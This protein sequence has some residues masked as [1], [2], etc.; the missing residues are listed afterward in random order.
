VTPAV[1][2]V[3]PTFDRGSVLALTLPGLAQQALSRGQFEILLIDDGSTDDTRAVAERLGGP[4]LRYLRFGHAGRAGARNRALDAARGDV[5]VFLDDDAFVPPG[6]L[7]AHRAMHDGDAHCMATG[8]IVHVAE[9]PRG[10]PSVAPWRGYHRNPF[11][12]GNASVR[13]DHALAVGGFDESLRLYGWEDVEFAT[14]LV[15]RGLRRRFAWAAPILHWKP[16]DARRRLAHELAVEGE[17]G[18]MGAHFYRKHRSVRVGL[19]T[20]MWWPIR[21]MDAALARV[22]PLDRLVVR[23][24]DR[25]ETADRMPA[26]A[27]TLLKYHAEISAGRRELARLARAP[28][29][30]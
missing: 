15:R 12:T 27:R 19:I 30:A 4:S 13:R 18:T 7:E 2:V 1:S 5:L 26:F 28:H 3:L 14:R 23:V 9:A 29:G 8:P 16:G 24:K 21:A 6:F 17:R 20:K 22:A 25:P 10:V 11:P